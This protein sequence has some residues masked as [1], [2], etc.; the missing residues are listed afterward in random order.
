MREVVPQPKRGFICQQ[1]S[2]LIRT[3]SAD[4]FS[5]FLVQKIT[6]KALKKMELIANILLAALHFLVEG[7]IYILFGILAAGLL[8]TFL[9]PATV[10]K[11]LGQ[12]RFLSVFK[13]AL[14]GIPIPL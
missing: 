13:A 6:C 4:D 9:N 14:F 1:I 2:A 7:G 3:F 12:G 11:H 10:A 5:C 8:K